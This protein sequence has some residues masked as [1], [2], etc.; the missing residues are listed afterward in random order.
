MRQLLVCVYL[1][2]LAKLAQMSKEQS[3]TKTDAEPEVRKRH[4]AHREEV[5][6]QTT[7]DYTKD[8]LEFVKRYNYNDELRDLW[9]IF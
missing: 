7:I 5:H 8:Q 1:E 9:A 6:Q 3:D 2:L 4:T